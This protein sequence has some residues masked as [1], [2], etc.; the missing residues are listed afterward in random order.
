MP[1]DRCVELRTNHNV[2]LLGW[3]YDPARAN[4]PINL[5][6][7]YLVTIGVKPSALP[8]Y[9]MA[10]S[11]TFY[12]MTGLIDELT[13]LIRC[14]TPLIRFSENPLWAWQFQN[15]MLVESS[16]G[17]ENKKIVKSAQ[18]NKVD[19]VQALCNALYVFDMLN[20]KVHK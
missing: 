19:N 18:E 20:S 6:K 14:E 2:N 3:G 17:M 4:D 16:D 7:N 15:C 10:V 9:V 13:Y 1:V 11:Q 12:T 5:L 8:D